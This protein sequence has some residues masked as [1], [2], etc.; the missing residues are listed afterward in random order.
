MFYKEK[1]S[2]LNNKIKKYIY[3]KKQ[4]QPRISLQNTW[5]ESFNKKK[6]LFGFAKPKFHF[7]FAL[8][9]GFWIFFWVFGGYKYVLQGIYDF[10]L[11][12]YD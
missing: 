6:I 10:F 11:L 9:V 1:K 4:H 12:K 3:I 2:I 8:I 5:Y 7:G